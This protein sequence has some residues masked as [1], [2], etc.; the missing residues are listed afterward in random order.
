MKHIFKQA[1]ALLL[2]ILLTLPL[3]ASCGESEGGQSVVEQGKKPSGDNGDLSLRGTYKTQKVDLGLAE[4]EIVLD[5]IEVDG[6]LRATI[7]V[8]DPEDNGGV[9]D[10]RAYL[11]E[12]R[13]YN[14]DY[15]KDSRESEKT[16]ARHE[17]T[18][19]SDPTVDLVFGG[20]YYESK[21]GIGVQYHL[22]RDGEMQKK[23]IGQ[24]MPDGFGGIAYPADRLAMFYAI[25]AH[26]MLYEDVPYI[27]Y[28]GGLT[29]VDNP[30]VVLRAEAKYG[31]RLYI[32]DHFV[33]TEAWVPGDPYYTFCG[34]IGIAGKPYALLEI[35]K[36]GKLIPLTPETT[37]LT[38]EGTEIEGCPTGGAFSDGKFGYFISGSELWQTNGKES[39]RIADLAPH[40]IGLSSLVRSVRALSDGRILVSAEGDLIELTPSEE[41]DDIPIYDIGIYDYRFAVH[42]GELSALVSEYNKQ[43]DKAYF[44]VKEFDKV[45]NMNLALLSGEVAMV[46]TPDRFAL[47]NYVKQELLAPLEDAAPALFEK[48]VLI[49]NVVDATRIGGVCYYLPT[50]FEIVGENITDPALL[51]GGKLFETRKE[52]YDFITANDPVYFKRRT[53]EEIFSQFASQLD[54]WIDWESHTSHFDDGTFEELLTFAAQGHPWEEVGQYFTAT[55]TAEDQFALTWI[56]GRFQLL[57][58]VGSYRFTDAEE[59]L[60]RRDTLDEVNGWNSELSSWVELDFPMPSTVHKG[61]EISARNYY[62]VVNDDKSREAAADFLTWLILED[63]EEFDEHEVT[64]QRRTEGFFINRD[65]TDRYLSVLID[66]YVDPEEEVAKLSEESKRD[67][68][69]VNSTRRLARIH[70]AKCGEEQ[71]EITW[72]Y[73]ESADHLAYGSNE[74]YD[75]MLEE[76]NRYFAGQITAKQAA[77]YVQNRISLNLAEQS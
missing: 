59:A 5:I 11:T 50:D 4:G 17:L 62:A 39:R 24:P 26:V 15:A 32:N 23:V 33:D 14:M 61:Y 21:Y 20:E 60:A 71:Y 31:E 34:L 16:V 76:A 28:N 49:E 13:W 54:E 68:L 40:G 56:A 58:T 43:S 35:D 8:P 44:H 73:I 67:R 53:K 55:A 25:M 7:G 69:T 51:K 57:D 22:Y 75:I 72:D 46:I 10:S 36:K 77:E 1:T 70:N 63:V 74:L 65:E 38:F 9:M 42:P 2:A 41:G 45:A 18:F 27:S 30:R 3:L 6:K 48:D 66:D 19:V 64:D 52:Y 37:E 29:S 47:N 12:R